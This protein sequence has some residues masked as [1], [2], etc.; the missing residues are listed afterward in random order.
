MP[1]GYMFHYIH[2]NLICDNQKLEKIQMSHNRKMDTENMVHLHMEYYLAIK[3]EGILSFA[4]KWM[5]P[6]N[7]ILSEVTQTQKHMH[8]L[9]SLING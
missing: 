5:E 9:Y 8:D 4:G 1:Q 7:I 2:S 6:E 3:S